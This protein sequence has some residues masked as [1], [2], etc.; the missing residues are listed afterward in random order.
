MKI[1]FK[2]IALQITFLLLAYIIHMYVSFLFASPGVFWYFWCG[3]HWRSEVSP[4]TWYLVEKKLKRKSCF[5]TDENNKIGKVFH[6]RCF[7]TQG[8]SFTGIQAECSHR[9]LDK[10]HSFFRKRTNV[11]RTDVRTFSGSRI[12]RIHY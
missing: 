3:V 10:S 1:S 12:H 6:S 9:I 11:T 5:S 2:I 4:F 7:S 8:W